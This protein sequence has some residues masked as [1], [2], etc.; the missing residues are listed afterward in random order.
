VTI[1]VYSILSVHLFQSDYGLMMTAI[2]SGDA[3]LNMLSPVVIPTMPP[4][5]H[6]PDALLAYLQQEQEK[7]AETG[8]N[9]DHIKR[10]FPVSVIFIVILFAVV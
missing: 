1:R 8:P 2:G 6:F 3:T 7:V 5:P 9:V 10:L 4:P